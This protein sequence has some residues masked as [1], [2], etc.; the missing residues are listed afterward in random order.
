MTVAELLS[1]NSV[2]YIKSYGS[3]GLSTASFR[4]T[5]AGH[6]QLTWN[7][8]NINNPM[9]GQF[10]LSLVPAGF[11][12][13]INITLWRRFNEYYTAGDPEV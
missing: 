10:D 8:I 1:E 11:I 9:V 3:G 6:T 2:I 13:D 5:G 12:D 4:G 7:D